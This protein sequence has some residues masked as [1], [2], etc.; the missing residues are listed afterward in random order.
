MAEMKTIEN[1]LEN[2]CGFKKVKV[3]TLA[4]TGT[5]LNIKKSKL[6]SNTKVYSSN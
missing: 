1:V 3:K 6:V 5:L 4:I 2:V